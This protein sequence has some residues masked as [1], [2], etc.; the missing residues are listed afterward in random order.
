MA[1]V[2]LARQDLQAR[3]FAKNPQTARLHRHR[4]NA[5][6]RVTDDS[7]QVEITG[8]GKRRMRQRNAIAMR[9]V[10]DRAID[11]VRGVAQEIGHACKDRLSSWIASLWPC[12]PLRVKIVNPRS[13][14]GHADCW[15]RRM[16]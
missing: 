5:V 12:D 14:G 10:D 9:I 2:L 13:L 7:D 8:V 6:D 4:Q 1:T 15:R 3:A 11:R 16:L